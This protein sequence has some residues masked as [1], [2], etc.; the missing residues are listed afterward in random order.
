MRTSAGSSAK[1]C[2]C[3]IVTVSRHSAIVHATG[4]I[5]TTSYGYLPNL[6]RRDGSSLAK[7]LRRVRRAYCRRHARQPLALGV[8]TSGVY[9]W[10]GQEKGVA[11]MHKRV[12]VTLPEETIRLIDRAAERGDRSRFI[13][14]AVRYF[15]RQRGRVQL[16]RLLEEGSERRAARDLAI[17]EEWF[18]VDKDAWRRRRK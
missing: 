5:F 11:T 12:N 6:V 3:S 17:A 15:V 9:A 10:F 2:P 7:R 13:D 8:H 1:R 14:A 4:M 18:P 16:R